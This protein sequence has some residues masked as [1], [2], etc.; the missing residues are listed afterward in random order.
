MLYSADVLPWLVD[1]FPEIIVGP[2]RMVEIQSKMRF[3]LC[4]GYLERYFCARSILVKERVDGLQQDGLPPGSHLGEL[5]IK[6]EHAMEIEQVPIKAV[7]AM[8]VRVRPGNMKVQVREFEDS[9]A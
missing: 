4:A 3:R 5:G 8:Q 6:S 2:V 9:I 7:L 1:R